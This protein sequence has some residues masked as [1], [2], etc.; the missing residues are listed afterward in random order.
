MA[1]RQIVECDLTKQET[2]ED[3][4]VTITIKVNGKKSR[5]YDL[6]P[7]SAAKLE[8]QLVAG[9][10][11]DHDWN[12]NSIHDNTSILKSNGA[13][14]TLGDL[15]DGDSTIVASKKAE[16]KEAGVLREQ[17]E[18]TVSEVTTI[19]GGDKDCRH[20]NKG[21]IQ[22]TLRNGKRFI[23]RPCKDCHARMPEMTRA[24]K[25]AYTEGKIVGEDINIREIERN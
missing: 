24:D 19:E 16:L 6:S 9:P 10:K 25:D 22:T 7:E 17:S 3:S 23:F 12:F 20:L 1:R 5:S 8:Q 15:D 4:L 2:N 13:P 21:R 14:K 11:L 18:S